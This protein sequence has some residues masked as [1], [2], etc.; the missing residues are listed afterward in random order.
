MFAFPT[1]CLR[2]PICHTSYFCFMELLRERDFITIWYDPRHFIKVEWRGYYSPDKIKEGCSLLLEC[3]V[4]KKCTKG[5]ND[6][7]QARGTFLQA[8]NWLREYFFPQLVVV[9]AEK[10]AFVLSPDPASRQSLE[11]ALE[12]NDQYE[13][14]V[15]ED[16]PMA[17]S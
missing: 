10:V 15:F 16:Y 2:L 9:G 13:G 1:K 12:L 3:F 8:V 17:E 7:R 5:L 6:A 4:E 11:R 14:Q